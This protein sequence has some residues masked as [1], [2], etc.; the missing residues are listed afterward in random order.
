[1]KVI[2]ETKLTYA[3]SNCRQEKHIKCPQRVCIGMHNSKQ[4][5]VQMYFPSIFLRS[6]SVISVPGMIAKR[7]SLIAR[8]QTEIDHA[9][10]Y[11]KKHNLSLLT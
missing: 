9:V 2:I 7:T 10:Q 3:S 6:V 5:T 1:M 11:V 4:H 8:Q